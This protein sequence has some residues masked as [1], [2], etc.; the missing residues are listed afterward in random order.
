M[1]NNRSR[2]PGASRGLG[3]TKPHV[4]M[5]DGRWCAFHIVKAGPES[6][7]IGAEVFGWVQYS[8]YSWL[9]ALDRWM[10]HCPTQQA[11]P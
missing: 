8:T 6:P 7:F 3:R 9:D 1:N 5:R 10:W 4:E 11:T 2:H